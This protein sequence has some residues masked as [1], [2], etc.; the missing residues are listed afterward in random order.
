M[1]LVKDDEIKEHF[2]W[3][4]DFEEKEDSGK[5]SE[6]EPVEKEELENTEKEGKKTKK[7]KNNKKTKKKKKEV[8]KY[9]W[10]VIVLIAAVS[11]I[12]VYKD[13]F[14][15][16]KEEAV[17]TVAVVNGQEISS[18][19][20]ETSYKLFVPEQMRMMMPKAAFLE[21]SLIPEAILTQ[22]AE[23]EG[24]S[25]DKEQIDFYINNLIARMG[26]TEDEFASELEMEGFTIEDIKESYRK[27]IMIAEL[28][29]KKISSS[30]TISDK[31][32]KDYYDKNKEEFS[33][34]EGQI[35]A[36]HILVETEEEANEILEGLDADEFKEVAF[37]KS[38]DLSAKTNKGELGFF[39]KGQMVPEFENAAF[40][41][42]VGEISAPVKSQFGYHIIKRESDIISFED[43]K[44]IINLSLFTAK[45]E[46][47]FETYVNQLKAK[48]DIKI[49]YTGE[50]M[51]IEEADELGG[52]LT[53][54]EEEKEVSFIETSD[55]VCKDDEKIIIRLFSAEVDPHSQWVSNVFNKVAKEY[56][57]KIIAYN[58]QIDTGD[59]LLTDAKEEKIP[60]SEVE[61][62]KKYNSAGSV[63]TFVFGCRYVRIGNG[64]EKENSL[65][66]EEA[67]F[68][69]II[70]K[71]I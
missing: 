7:K 68:R 14:F 62:Y 17:K 39:S 64:Y 24:I 15:P 69:K 34:G 55:A 40:S 19:E 50:G 13:S 48:A 71:L 30:I 12:I 32:I 67:E 43:A 6:K 44:Q 47:A 51:T 28:L 5:E 42:K 10:A 26:A 35:R 3:E 29:D 1:I 58:W 59:N 46:S 33:A 9:V 63:P 23:R 2:S 37:E 25:A 57:G 11:L 53:E 56:S 18:D 4:D 61:I 70:E 49:F 45:Q 21:E 27:K 20:L 41:L 66:E 38:I 52:D 36:S 54:L 60:K 16:E 8:K 22:E 31:E 65:E